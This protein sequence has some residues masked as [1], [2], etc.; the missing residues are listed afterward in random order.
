MIAR[1]VRTYHRVCARY[2]SHIVA[3]QREVGY[4]DTH[5]VSRLM[6]HTSRSW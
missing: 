2:W 3:E 5:A 1:L 6:H 4:R